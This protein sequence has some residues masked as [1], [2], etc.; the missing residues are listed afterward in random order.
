MGYVYKITCIPSNKSYIGISVH[1][2]EKYRIREHLSGKGNRYIANAVKKYGKDAF[3]HEI[4]EENVF[5]ELLPDLEVA[6]I[7]KFNTVRPNGFNL[8]SG[9]EGCLGYK[10]TEESRLKMS[11]IQ[12]RR[13]RSPHSLETRR[14]ISE[15]HTGKK[16]SPEHIRKISE[17]KKGK[18]SWHKG[19]KRSKETCERIGRASKGRVSPN[20]GKPRTQKEKENISR[21]VKRS[22]KGRSPWNKGKSLSQETRDKISQTKLN[23][24]PSQET[25]EKIGS[26]NRG[27]TLSKEIRE[28]MS[29]AK[30]GKARSP[31]K[32]PA[33]EFFLSLPFEMSLREKRHLLQ[34]KFPHKR[35]STLNRWVRQWEDKKL[36]SSYKS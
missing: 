32:E 5:P 14:N 35:K 29:R 8:T 18:P 15:A 6:Y 11:K 36:M 1:E 13:K 17:A 26:A 22:L 25:R 10:H 28:K 16:K 23:N 30:L 12:K 4:L 2:P 7:K 20:K 34:K 33:R 19:K 24:P 3:T 31:D 21:A 27:K 9:G